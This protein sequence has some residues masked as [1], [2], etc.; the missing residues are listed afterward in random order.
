G[1]LAQA[2]ALVHQALGEDGKSEDPAALRLAVDISLRQNRSDLAGN[3]VARVEKAPAATPGDKA[4]AN[5]T[6]AALLLARNRQADRNQALSL[7]ERNL[8]I[9]PESVEDQSLSAAILAFRP[10]TQG[11]AIAVL[12][13]LAR[14]N[15]LGDAERFLLARLYLGR[16]EEQKYQDEMQKLCAQKTRNPQQLAQFA[17]HWIDRNQL[18]Q[19]DH[20]LAELKKDD[21]QGLPALEVEARLLDLRKRKLELLALLE[22]R[23]REVPDQIGPVADLLYRYGFAKEAEA[24]YKAFIARAPGQ[25]EPSL[26]LAV[27]LA[28]ENRASEAIPILKK[29]WA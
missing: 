4:W 23:V 9:D 21:P 14:T 12:E 16:G 27:F 10:A 24:A 11:E 3:Y 1:D 18:D 28:R 20:W 29:A 5:R 8:A 13:R 19:A 17:G 26:A 7:V 6:R 22:S 2:E 15:R 25:P